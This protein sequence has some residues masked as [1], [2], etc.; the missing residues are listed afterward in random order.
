V[1]EAQL[2]Q[3]MEG[4]QEEVP[5]SA[6]RVDEL[7]FLVPEGL[8]RGSQRAVEDELLDE[9]G[10]LK[11][12]VLLARCFRQVLVEVSEKAGVPGGIGEVMVGRSRVR[13][14]ALPEPQKLGRPVSREPN[15]PQRVVLLIEELGRR[16]KSLDGAKDVEEVLAVGLSK[17]RLEV[18]R[19]LIESVL[20]PLA[21]ARD[22]RNFDELV[23]LEKSHEDRPQDPGDGDL[24]EQL[25][26]PRFERLSSSSG[27]LRAPEL[28]SQ[29]GVDR[30]LS[31][32]SLA[33]VFF[34]RAEKLLEVG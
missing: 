21:A 1:L 17:V 15:Q 8:D 29:V 28:L 9:L 18:E 6:S 7:H 20:A 13:I 32:G 5:G 31:R 16:G 34:E 26:A 4:S 2:E 24:G 14:H 27:G 10:R 12:R 11:E 23:V 33:K 25:V 22:S 3:A 19:V 30:L